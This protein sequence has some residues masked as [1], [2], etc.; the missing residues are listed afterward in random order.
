MAD[1]ANQNPNPKLENLRPWKPGQ[2]GNPKGRP[3][4]KPMKAA[5]EAAAEAD[6][7]LVADLVRVG[8]TQAKGG[9]FRYWKEIWDR[10]DGKVPAPV[11]VIQDDGPDYADDPEIE[12]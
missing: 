8:I 6:P 10:F 12:P 11:E 2:S 9:D 7:D 5:L 3:P 1:M 4:E